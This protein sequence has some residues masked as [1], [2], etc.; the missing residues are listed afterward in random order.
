M[1]RSAFLALVAVAAVSLVPSAPWGDD[2]PIVAGDWHPRESKA[3]RQQID[4]A[5]IKYAEALNTTE[6][7]GVGARTLQALGLVAV[8][9]RLPED[10]REEMLRKAIAV[11]EEERKDFWPGHDVDP[12]AP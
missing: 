2:G 7:S 9:P 12:A 5:V 11:V 1:R 8:L 6:Y 3:L 4:A 10:K